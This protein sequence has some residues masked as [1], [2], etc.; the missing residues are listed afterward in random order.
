[1]HI[2]RSPLKLDR[3]A[4]VNDRLSGYEFDRGCEE[5]WVFYGIR[6]ETGQ[7]LVKA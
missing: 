6:D 1:M 7:G 4:V 5:T 3:T 2:G